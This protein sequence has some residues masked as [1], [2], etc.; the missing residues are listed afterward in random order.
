M[1]EMYKITRKAWIYV[2]KS[3]KVAR[4]TSNSAKFGLAKSLEFTHLVGRIQWREFAGQ[5]HACTGSV[6][7][8]NL[9]AS[10]WNC[11][12][13]AMNSSTDDTNN[14]CQSRKTTW[15]H[16]ISRANSAKFSLAKSLEFSH[17]MQIV[18]RIYASKS[19][20]VAQNRLN[21]APNSPPMGGDGLF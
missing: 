21:S 1:S 7:C 8:L 4:N 16:L 11:L 6:S 5:I 15:I 19:R 14:P 17:Q 20:E 3:R 13:S 2:S 10:L 18:A 12:K 9:R